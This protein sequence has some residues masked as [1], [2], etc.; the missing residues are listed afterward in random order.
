MDTYL[1]RDVLGELAHMTTEDK[2]HSR[3]PASYRP[4]DA[5]SMTQFKS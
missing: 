5:D 2:S 3:Q 4:W 1:S